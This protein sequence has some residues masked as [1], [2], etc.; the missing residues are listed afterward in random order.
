MRTTRPL[1]NTLSTPPLS[2]HGS[3]SML[4]WLPLPGDAGWAG[5]A[6]DRSCRSRKG[7]PPWRAWRV[8]SRGA[9]HVGVRVRTKLVK[10]AALERG[11]GDSTPNAELRMGPVDERR[12]H[13]KVPRS[14][15]LPASQSRPTVA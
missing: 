13:Q 4:G 12:P 14:L 11:Q 10:S 2:R 15:S 6:P 5:R 9:R 7:H 3:S 8:A 1:G